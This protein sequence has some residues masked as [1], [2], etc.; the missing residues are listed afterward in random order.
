M[1]W[2]IWS[3]GVFA[4]GFYLGVWYSEDWKIKSFKRGYDVGREHGYQ[5]GRFDERWNG[6]P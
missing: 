6:Q 1:F 3:I 2:F 5:Y 4:L